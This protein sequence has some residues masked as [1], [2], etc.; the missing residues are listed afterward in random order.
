MIEPKIAAAGDELHEAFEALAGRPEAKV[1][2][3]CEHA[4]QRLPEGYAWPQEDGRLVGTHWAF[5][6]GAA[7]ITHALASRIGAPAV[8]SRFTRLLID[9][10]RPEDSTTLFRTEAEGGPVVLNLDLTE[11][12]KLRRI[13]RLY[14]PYHRAIDQRLGAHGAQV[15]FSIHT[16][17][18]V[19]EGQVRQME[20]GVLFDTQDALAERAAVALRAAGFVTAMN[21]PYSGKEGLIHAAEHHAGAHGRRA[22]ELEVRQDLAVRPEVQARLAAVFEAFFA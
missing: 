1:F 5:D 15:L 14:R 19:Y 11:A 9:P 22:L 8:L 20:V 12:E 2:L 3:S 6:P 21:E 18:P 10:N 16:F 13:E 17:T 4:S 7:A